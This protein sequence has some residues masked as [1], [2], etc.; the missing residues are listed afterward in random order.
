LGLAAELPAETLKTPFGDWRVAR[1]A[2]Y[3]AAITA[4]T[5]MMTSRDFFNFRLLQL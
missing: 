3:V 1:S 5:A 2:R 4:T